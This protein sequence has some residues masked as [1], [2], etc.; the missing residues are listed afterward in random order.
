MSN[1]GLHYIADMHK[2]QLEDDLFDKESFY[3]ESIYSSAKEANATILGYTS[4]KFKPYGVTSLLLLAES[5]IAIHSWYEEKYLSVDIYT[6]GD[7]AMPYKA[8]EYLKQ[9]FKPEV[10]YIKKIE[11]GRSC[12]MT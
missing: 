8:V 1:K 2:C 6:C 5:H 9:A 3:K 7:S 4:H 12:L 11:R 10:C